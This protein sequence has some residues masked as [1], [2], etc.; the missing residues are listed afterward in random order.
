MSE[1]IS[2][3]IRCKDEE[4]WIGHTIQSCIDNIEC[5]Y[6]GSLYLNEIDLSKILFQKFIKNSSKE[7]EVGIIH[8]DSIFLK[9]EPIFNGFLAN[10]FITNY[11]FF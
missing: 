1:K 9:K 4:R 6:L 5:P 3:V 8:L 7:F 2:V 11:S 10:I